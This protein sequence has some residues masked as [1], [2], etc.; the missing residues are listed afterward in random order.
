[1]GGE[2]TNILQGYG[3]LRE[4]PFSESPHSSG[5]IAPGKHFKSLNKITIKNLH[6][7]YNKMCIIIYTFYCKKENGAC[8]RSANIRKVKVKVSSVG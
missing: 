5:Q 3:Y 7:L 8:V 4:T 6:F 2:D 1:M